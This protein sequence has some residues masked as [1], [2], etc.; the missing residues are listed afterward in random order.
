MLG[1]A[2]SEPIQS[3][4][5]QQVSSKTRGSAFGRLSDRGALMRHD[6]SD[7][8]TATSM[9]QA[10]WTRIGKEQPDQ[11]SRPVEAAGRDGCARHKHFAVREKRLRKDRAPTRIPCIRYRAAAGAGSALLTADAAPARTA[12]AMIAP[13]RGYAPDISPT[14]AISP[15]AAVSTTNWGAGRKPTL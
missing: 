15:I 7:S 2:I 9:C 5:A 1:V 13:I 4:S 11:K 3:K 10:L 6:D 12:T 8:L 14:A